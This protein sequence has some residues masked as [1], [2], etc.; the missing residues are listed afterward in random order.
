MNTL[1][2]REVSLLSTTLHL[3][4]EEKFLFLFKNT[5]FNND[6]D[7]ELIFWFKFSPG[8]FQVW[9]ACFG[10]GLVLLYPWF[11][12]GL[13]FVKADPELV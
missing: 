8:F 1:Y 11:S 13:V 4:L 3:H 12:L 7:L 6:L 2:F 10:L 9:P 5:Y